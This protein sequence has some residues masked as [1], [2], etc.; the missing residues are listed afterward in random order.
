MRE[1]AINLLRGEPGLAIFHVE[2]ENQGPWRV[3]GLKD[4]LARDPAQVLQGKDIDPSVFAFRM[5][6]FVSHDP[7]MVRR[8]V[9][10]AILPPEG[11]SF[12]LHDGVLRLAGTASVE[13]I[14]ET[15]NKALLLPGIR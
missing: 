12:S 4:E 6:P 14:L 3:F 5:L 11:A 2:I 9:D 1:E 7:D 15:R 8:R 13:W 10:A